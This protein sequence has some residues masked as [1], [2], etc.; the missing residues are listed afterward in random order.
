MNAKP[1][2]YFDGG[3]MFMRKTGWF[4]FFS[5]R[6]NNF[7]N[8]NQ[9]GVICVGQSCAVNQDGILQDTNPMKPAVSFSGSS[10]NRQSPSYCVD[11][12]NNGQA[13]AN[14]AATCIGG[15]KENPRDPNDEKDIITTDKVATNEGDSDAKGEGE[16]LGCA[17]QDNYGVTTKQ[18]N[19]LTGEEAAGLAIGIIAATILLSY[20]TYWVCNRYNP[21][22]GLFEQGMD[23]DFVRRAT[24]YERADIDE[25]SNNVYDDVEMQPT[26][27]AEPP[28]RYMEKPKKPSKPARAPAPKVREEFDPVAPSVPLRTTRSQ[29][30]A[31][32]D[33]L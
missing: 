23:E 17:T 20:F 29:K 7:S 19:G 5:S 27:R 3:V 18:Q 22:K 24:R 10:A 25:P 16:L 32:S 15:T 31:R 28:A 14:G 9:K 21:R 26:K 11:T 4:P 8:R 12:S 13:N 6:N 33:F 2:P 1:Y 30:K